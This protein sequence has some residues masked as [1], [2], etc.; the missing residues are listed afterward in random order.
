MVERDVRDSTNLSY[1]SN[2]VL[3]LCIDFIFFC[4][5]LVSCLWQV[6]EGR[7]MVSDMIHYQIA[8][9]KSVTSF[10]LE[11]LKF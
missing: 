4:Y 5:R 8:A 9:L 1:V 3:F 6:E 11:I 10:I 2:L 7:D